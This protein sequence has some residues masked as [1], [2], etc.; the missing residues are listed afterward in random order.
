MEQMNIPNPGQ[1]PP[2]MEGMMGPPPPGM[3]G[4]M[5][6]PPGMEGMMGPPPGMG[7][8]PNMEDMEKMLNNLDVEKLKE[9]LP[10]FGKMMEMMEQTQQ[11]K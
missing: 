2:G 5:G 6:P 7:G 3:G 4:M 1:T 8:M 10:Q 11:K 9:M